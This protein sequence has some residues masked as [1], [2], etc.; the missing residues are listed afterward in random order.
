MFG[1]RPSAPDARN[2]P[3]RAFLEAKQPKVVGGTRMYLP[4]PVLDQGDTGVCVGMAGRAWMNGEP[5]MFQAGLSPY[6]LYRRCVAIDEWADNDGDANEPNDQ[7]LQAGTSVHALAKV[8]LAE[9]RIAEYRWTQSVDEI[10]AFMLGN[11][12]TVVLGI[13]WYSGMMTPS[14]RNIIRRTGYWV[15]GHAID[16]VGWS[17]TVLRGG[18]V[19]I[20]NSWGTSWGQGGFAWLPANDLQALLEEDGECMVAIE[21]DVAT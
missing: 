7:N 12:G 21:Q 16:T 5:V 11:L 17:D 19:Q 14:V 10:R 8:L 6:A 13:S 15:G 20:Q 3:L 4:G 1:R 2:R 18:A 9:G